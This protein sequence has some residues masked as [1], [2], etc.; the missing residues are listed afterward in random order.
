MDNAFKYLETTGLMTEAEYPYIARRHLFFK[1]CDKTDE[2]KTRVSAYSD[3]P[4]KNVAQMKAALAKGPVSIAIE[5]DKS[6]FQLYHTGVLTSASCGTNLD[7]GVLAVGYGTEDGQDFFLVKNS[8]GATWGE[9][10]FIKLGTNNVCGMLQQASW[11]KTKET[12]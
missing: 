7:H 12:N 10:G 2:A 1:Q 11:P 4:A 3:V 6:V 9:K 8:W 5:A